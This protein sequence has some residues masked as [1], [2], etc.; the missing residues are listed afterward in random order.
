MGL[1]GKRGQGIQQKIFKLLSPEEGLSQIWK[2]SEEF[3]TVLGIVH[4]KQKFFCPLPNSQAITEANE[5]Q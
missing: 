3:I 5:C 4:I 1:M 2:F